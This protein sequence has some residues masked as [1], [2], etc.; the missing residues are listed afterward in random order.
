MVKA[1]RAPEIMPGMIS[2][3]TTFVERLKRRAAEVE[4][5]FFQVRVHLLELRHDVQDDIREIERDVRDE[6]RPET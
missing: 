4:R 1:I 6:K 2:W 5:G 3:M